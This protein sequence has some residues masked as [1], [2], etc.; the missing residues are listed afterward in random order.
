[1][2]VKEVKKLV[3]LA[4]TEFFSKQPLMHGAA[5]AYYALLAMVPLLY[6]SITYIGRLIGQDVILELITE[7]L[8]ERV[9]IKDVSGIINFLDDVDIARGSFALQLIG[10]FTLMLSCSVIFN[11]LKKSMNTFYSI[12][13][14]DIGRKQKIIKGLLTRLIS[15]CFIVGFTILFVVVYFAETIFLSIG[16]QFFKEVKMVSWI[17][18]SFAQH[19]I[20]ILTNIIVFSFIFKYLHDGMVAW[21]M[22]IR[23]AV[24]TSF[25]LY[26][27]QL[28]L[29]YYLTNFFFASNGGVA[30][31]MLII[32]VWVYYSSQIIFIGAKFIEVISKARG[33]PVKHND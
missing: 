12:D 26:L 9:G 15:M 6:L 11:S 27:G 14:I 2:T 33:L 30:G 10:I 5:L 19:G 17:F 4:F 23:G 22:A 31:A 32:L 24:L 8:Q 13:A 18:S 7:L 25:L 28:L 1:M 29:K 20:P 21:K 3:F 16:N